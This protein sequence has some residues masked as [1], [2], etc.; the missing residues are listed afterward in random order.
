MSCL[1]YLFLFLNV[2]TITPP[3]SSC[4]P[5]MP[6]CHGARCAARSMRHAEAKPTI[7]NQ[8]RSASCRRHV[9]RQRQPLPLMI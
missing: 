3:F 2:V 5:A 4:H 6:L 8:P 9:P 7:D 1:F